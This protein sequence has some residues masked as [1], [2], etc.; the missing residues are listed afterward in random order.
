VVVLRVGQ[1]L[2]AQAVP[3][4]QMVTRIFVVVVV[5]VV[6]L[7]LRVQMAPVE[8]EVMVVP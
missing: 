6:R 3:Q 8:T 5:V 1:V 2:Q 4:A 7:T